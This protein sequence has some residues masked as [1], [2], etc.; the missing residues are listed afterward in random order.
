MPEYD[1]Y[2]NVKPSGIGLYVRRG[3]ALPDFADPE[4]WLFD[5]TA[6]QDLLPPRVVE[7]VEADGL[8]LRDMD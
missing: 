8:A 5:G 7:S 6:E 4:D 1:R 3:A 2:I